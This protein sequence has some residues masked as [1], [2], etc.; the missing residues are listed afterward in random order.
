MK[1]L[2]AYSLLITLVFPCY[3]SYPR[4]FLS[5]LGNLNYNG[6]VLGREA[7]SGPI[8][9]R[10]S[11]RGSFWFVNKNNNGRQRNDKDLR[12]LVNLQLQSG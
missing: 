9:A 12:K 8:E 4:Y 10:V 7:F 1:L 6:G 5:D 2:N 3:L 11:K